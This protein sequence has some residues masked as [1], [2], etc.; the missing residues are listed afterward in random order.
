MLTVWFLPARVS[1][2]VRVL[3]FCIKTAES[4]TERARAKT[5]YRPRVFL[6][7]SAVFVCIRKS[8]CAHTQTDTHTHRFCMHRQP[9]HLHSAGVCVCVRSTHTYSLPAFVA[10]SHPSFCLPHTLALRNTRL[11]SNSFLEPLHSNYQRRVRGKV[12]SRDSA[13]HSPFWCTSEYFKSRGNHFQLA[14]HQ[15]H[16]P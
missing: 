1:S 6:C 14:Y 11:I 2:R 10:G 8:T 15:L 12:S 9:T 7:S 3:R 16:L 13:A 4:Q 5:M